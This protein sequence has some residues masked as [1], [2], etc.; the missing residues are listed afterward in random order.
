MLPKIN[1]INQLNRQ[2]PEDGID[3]YRIEKKYKIS[4][5][6]CIL[7]QSVKS[8]GLIGVECAAS[9]GNT[10]YSSANKLLDF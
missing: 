8:N 9:L 7:F 2:A 4:N 3:L 10:C 5:S 1:S 6:T